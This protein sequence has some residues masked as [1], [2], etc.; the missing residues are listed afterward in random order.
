[1][2]AQA[3]RLVQV[4]PRTLNQHQREQ[5]RRFGVELIE[6]KDWR[7]GVPLRFEQPV[8][9]SFDLDVLEPGLVPGISH[10]EAGGLSV[11][12]AIGIVQRF[13][14]ALV[15][16]GQTTAQF[17]ASSRADGVLQ[18]QAVADGDLKAVN[19]TGALIGSAQIIAHFVGTAVHCGPWSGARNVAS[20]DLWREDSGHASIKRQD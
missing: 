14:G 15:G 10:R 2:R 7:D 5:A 13:E 4:G 12:Q 3:D 18:G 20:S 9:L 16:A 17:G 1:M 8:Y 6:M 19:D 11:R